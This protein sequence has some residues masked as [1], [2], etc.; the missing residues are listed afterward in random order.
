MNLANC[1]L[2]LQD[3]IDDIKPNNHITRLLLG[4]LPPQ[5]QIPLC[6]MGFVAKIQKAISLDGLDTSLPS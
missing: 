4:D 2:G 5:M 6:T 3:I 1:G